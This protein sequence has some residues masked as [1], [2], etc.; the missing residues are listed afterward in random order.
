MQTGSETRPA[1]PERAPPVAMAAVLLLGAAMLLSP[2]ERVFTPAGVRFLADEDPLYHVLRAERILHGEPGALWADPG[3]DYPLGAR[4]LWPPGY[5]ALIAG[6]ARL[7]GGAGASRADLERVAAFA[8]VAWGLAALALFTTLATAWLGRRAGLVA[9][10]LAAVSPM[11]ALYG[12]LGRPDHHVAELAMFCAVLLAFERAARRAQAGTST[13]ALAL[14]LAAAPWIWQGAALYPV[15]LA[16]FVAVLHVV[17]PAGVDAARAA[18]ALAR[19]ALAGAVLLGLSLVLLQPPDALRPH[20]LNGISAFHPFLLLGVGGAMAALSRMGGVPGR[21]GPAARTVQALAAGLVPSLLLGLAF[22]EA[23]AHGLR[24]LGAVDP[25]YRTID[26]QQPLFFGARYA[27]QDELTHAATSMGPLLLA[28]LLAIASFRRRWAEAPAE[29]L[30]LALAAFGAALFLPLTLHATRFGIYLAP[31]AE[32]AGGLLVAGLWERRGR[33]RLLAG[34]SLALLAYPAFFLVRPGPAPAVEEDLVSA[35]SWLRS[36]ARPDRAVLAPWQLGH[37]VQYYAGLP[38]VVTPFATDLGPG[39]M[40]D[41]A[42]FLYAPTPEAAAEVLRRRRV[43]YLLFGDMESPVANLLDF[44]PPGAPLLV[45]SGFGRFRGR[46]LEALP[47]YERSIPSWLFDFDGVPERFAD[48]E[49]L[50]TYRLVYETRRL[51]R[52]PYRLF[53]VVEGAVLEVTGAGASERVTAAAP[54]MT[55]QGRRFTWWTAARADAAGRAWLRV[56]YETGLNGA[57]AVGPYT[58][59]AGAHLARVSVGELAVSRGDRIPCDLAEP[60]PPPR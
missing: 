46:R 2:W 25:I 21:A 52:I 9:A 41:L 28:P 19:G 47:A 56:P 32:L 50:G 53:E 26:E 18:R 24:V 40:R 55:N 44:A 20:S 35:L 10:L 4:I 54:V 51:P 5:D 59:R 29:R 7:L 36:R 58:V 22:P 48:R 60:V 8:P 49:A 23:V 6:A 13:A 27:L 33:W 17:Q 30:G 16:V 12:L 37:A 34:A 1:A 3:L 15:A 43:G 14:L 42:A 31:F 57:V 39:G 38:A 11:G 45:R